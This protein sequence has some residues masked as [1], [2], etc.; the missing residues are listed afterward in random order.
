MTTTTDDA[1]NA[2]EVEDDGCDEVNCN[3]AGGGGWRLFQGNSKDTDDRKIN[4]HPLPTA[5]CFYFCSIMQC[6]SVRSIVHLSG[7]L[8][9][10]WMDG[11]R[12]D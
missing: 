2:E 11:C 12:I 5:T 3:P 7:W 4:L 10:W 8:A 9:G 1:L 6:P